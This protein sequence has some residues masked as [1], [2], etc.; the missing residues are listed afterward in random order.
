LV[1]DLCIV[2][3]SES[4]WFYCERRLW[5]IFHSVVVGVNCFILLGLNMWHLHADN[6]L[7]T[8]SGNECSIQS[9][10]HSR[11]LNLCFGLIWE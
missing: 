9:K 11:G 1:V 3:N 2:R 8:S 4:L 6:A 7:E 10:M 5:L